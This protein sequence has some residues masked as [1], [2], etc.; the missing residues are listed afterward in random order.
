MP[1]ELDESSAALEEAADISN[2]TLQGM[3][4]DNAGP[5]EL[6]ILGLTLIAGGNFEKAKEVL[7]KLTKLT[8]KNHEAWNNL[9]L[10]LRNLGE[11]KEA[12]KVL[13]KA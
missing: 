2:E 13:Q 5:D 6:K 4:L 9:G 8:P 7:L 10:T 1:D 12:I 11:H 3:D